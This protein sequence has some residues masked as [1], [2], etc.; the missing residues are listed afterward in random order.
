MLITEFEKYINESNVK[1]KGNFTFKIDRT[2]SNKIYNKLV[3]REGVAVYPYACDNE[4]VLLYAL[5]NKEDQIEFDQ[6]HINTYGRATSKISDRELVK[7]LD[8]RLQDNYLL[9]C[10]ETI[11]R[12]LVY[13]YKEGLIEDEFLKSSEELFKNQRNLKRLSNKRLHTISISGNYIYFGNNVICEN[14]L[15]TECDNEIV[16]FK[17][18]QD[19]KVAYT[20]KDVICHLNKLNARVDVLVDRLLTRQSSTKALTDTPVTSLCKCLMEGLYVYRTLRN[21]ILSEHEGFRI[22]RALVDSDYLIHSELSHHFKV[23]HIIGRFPYISM[24]LSLSKQVSSLFRRIKLCKDSFIITTP[25]VKKTF[26]SELDLFK[27]VKNFNEDNLLPK[28]I[29][30]YKADGKIYNLNRANPNVLPGLISIKKDFVL[31]YVCT[32]INSY[33]N[34][35]KSINLN[36]QTTNLEISDIE[37]VVNGYLTYEECFPLKL[38]LAV[39]YIK[40]VNNNLIKG[41]ALNVNASIHKAPRGLFEYLTMHNTNNMQFFKGE[42][43]LRV[44]TPCKT[45]GIP[46]VISWDTSKKKYYT[47]IRFKCA[48]WVGIDSVINLTEFVCDFENSSE[49]ATNC[50]KHLDRVL[51]NDVILS[52][53]KNSKYIANINKFYSVVSDKQ[54]E[55]PH[56]PIIQNKF[57]TF[58]SALKDLKHLA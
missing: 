6:M 21:Q 27:F 5:T 53:D 58:V 28:L 43:Y 15:I 54:K 56:L 16:G 48:N 12:L 32:D 13:F 46:S 1:S 25:E 39:A 8:N 36:Q 44:D 52:E 57:D 35:H 3:K 2:L 50:I 18:F 14:D 49:F 42:V 51:D 10:N 19:D 55:S 37:N 20:A 30:D 40:L 17:L 4:L 41:S 33:T 23:F 11:I 22:Y 31:L 45:K 24:K 38:A 47:T 7:L 9:P 34:L 29:I 26:T